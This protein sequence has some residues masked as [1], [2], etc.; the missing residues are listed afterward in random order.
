MQE[1]KKRRMMGGGR[2]MYESRNSPIQSCSS[3]NEEIQG[4]VAGYH[5]TG[6]TV[7]LACKQRGV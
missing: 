1:A 4:Q 7:E 2:R 6:V 5:T 3:T